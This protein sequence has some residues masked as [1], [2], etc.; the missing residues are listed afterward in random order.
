M[1]DG[2]DKEVE[3]LAKKELRAK[4]LADIICQ[5]RVLK[6]G[7]IDPDLALDGA[8]WAILW[9]EDFNRLMQERPPE[10]DEDVIRLMREASYSSLLRHESGYRY[11]SGLPMLQVTVASYDAFCLSFEGRMLEASRLLEWNMGQYDASAELE[12]GKTDE[13]QSLAGAMLA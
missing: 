4:G 12:C 8:R 3:K 5:T 10:N 2:F 7:P 9:G 13:L 11:S 6:M 1:G